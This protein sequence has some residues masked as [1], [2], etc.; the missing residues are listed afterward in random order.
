MTP[1]QIKANAPDEATSYMIHNDKVYYL[2]YENG[3]WKVHFNYD[4]RKGWG[5]ANQTVIDTNIH[6]LKRLY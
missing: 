2:K 5:L 1:E 3:E 4:D 6:L